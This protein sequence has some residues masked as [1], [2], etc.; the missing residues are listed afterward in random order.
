MKFNFLRYIYRSIVENKG[1]RK[2]DVR[3]VIGAVASTEV[4]RLVGWEFLKDKWNEI[5]N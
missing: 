2:Q 3:T 5:K 4:G 1:I